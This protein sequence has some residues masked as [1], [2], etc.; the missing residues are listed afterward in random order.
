MNRPAHPSGDRCPPANPKLESPVKVTVNGVETKVHAQA[1]LGSLLVEL[2]LHLR[3]CT[4]EVNEQ[5]IPKA[6]HEQHRLSEGDR[7][8][9]VTLVGGG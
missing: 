9:I 5:L 3:A 8:E 7:I 1:T 2:G 4:A 6:R